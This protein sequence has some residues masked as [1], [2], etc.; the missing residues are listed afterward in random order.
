MQAFALAGAEARDEG[1]RAS[2]V[3][4]R[5]AATPPVRKKSRRVISLP[6]STMWLLSYCCMAGLR[7]DSRRTTP[8]TPLLV[9]VPVSGIGTY[10]Q[11]LACLF[12][13]LDVALVIGLEAG[14]VV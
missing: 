14:L 9:L 11:G 5:P 8:D 3:R 13:D 7:H 1:R 4:P 2:P 12:A 6:N 10:S